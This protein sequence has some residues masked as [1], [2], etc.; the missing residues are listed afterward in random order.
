M[1]PPKLEKFAIFMSTR[2]HPNSSH[3]GRT[4]PSY[5]FKGIPIRVYSAKG[6]FSA[7]FKGTDRKPRRIERGTESEAVDAA[8]AEIRRMT[9]VEVQ[10]ALREEA[11]AAEILKHTDVSVTE[12]ARLIATY[13]ERLAPF[14]ASLGDAVDYFIRCHQ[15]L[16]ITVRDLVKALLAEKSSA[17]GDK[18]VKDLRCRL[19]NRFCASYGDRLVQS[20]RS[21]E[22]SRWLNGLVCS[23]RNKRNYHASVVTLFEFAKE[24][25]YLPKGKPSEIQLIK[26]KKAN[27]IDVEI[28]TPDELI[29]MIRS[30]LVIKSPAL[31]ALLIQSLAGL[32]T[33]EI[34]QTDEKK[35]RLQWKDVRLG[36]SFPDVHVRKKVSK[37]N[38]ERFAPIAPALSTWL[39]RLR[40]K[41]PGPV[42]ARTSLYKDYRRI[43]AHAKI[44][45]R[46]NG[47]RKSFNTY[48]VALSGSAQLTAKK[49]GNSADMVKRF[50][51][52]EISQASLVALEWFSITP[53]K[54]GELVKDYIA[55][56]KAFPPKVGGRRV[57]RKALAVSFH[58]QA[59]TEAKG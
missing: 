9:D 2:P 18:N 35:D 46:R 34:E 24:N 45:W 31:V 55:H 53:G 52:K 56:I 42:Y 39:R 59:I 6:R 29:R 49:A 58:T 47:L 48:D 13:K 30:A 57:R 41:A 16:P 26:K 21:D 14:D 51:K 54:F 1:H 22:L 32:R 15:C 20:I 8:K 5:E 44:A 36:Q 3:N 23:Q 33:E 27:V 28:F 43:C 7:Q 38:R 17:T 37:T 11:M 50:Y 25:G 40:S 4:V 10:I 19:E 12:A